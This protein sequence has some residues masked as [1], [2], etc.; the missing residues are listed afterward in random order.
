MI[1]NTGSLG[2]V[3]DPIAG[4]NFLNI[5]LKVNRIIVHQSSHNGFI[6]TGYFQFNI[7]FFIDYYKKLIL[8]LFTH[9]MVFFQIGLKK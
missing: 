5:L 4:L 6:K 8:K 1:Y 9:L 7:S 2:Y 3:N